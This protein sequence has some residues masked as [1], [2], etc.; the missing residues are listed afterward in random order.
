MSTIYND[1]S[2]ATPSFTL[3][4]TYGVRCTS[5]PQVYQVLQLG[6]MLYLFDIASFHLYATNTYSWPL[7]IYRISCNIGSQEYELHQLFKAT[8]H[9][10]ATYTYSWPIKNYGISCNIGSQEYELQQLLTAT[11]HLHATYAYHLYICRVEATEL[12]GSSHGCEVLYT[13][14]VCIGINFALL[15]SWQKHILSTRIYLQSELI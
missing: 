12:Q 5:D 11:S 13:S 6:Y 14:I 8:S 3:Y 2:S 7:N 9:L 1:I 10:H 4:I 15:H